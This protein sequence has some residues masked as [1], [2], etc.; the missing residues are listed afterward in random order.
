MLGDV[1]RNAVLH[2]AATAMVVRPERYVG[3][4]V[5]RWRN[6]NFS[7]RMHVS[8]RWRIVSTY[9][10]WYRCRCTWRVFE[11]S[12]RYVVAVLINNAFDDLPWP[13]RR[14]GLRWAGRRA[15]VERS[16]YML[17]FHSTWLRRSRGLEATR[18]WNFEVT[19]GWRLGATRWLKSEATG[20][21][22][23]RITR[24]LRSES[25]RCL[26]FE[27]ARCLVFEATRWSCFN[28]LW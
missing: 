19:R 12:D 17:T 10:G 27:F 3:V 14:S 7:N 18:C 28:A 15:E 25:I 23:L 21:W 11:R 8:E 26:S 22:G 1:A 13:R 5:G 24:C 2:A 9:H 4:V 6:L 20:C 16:W